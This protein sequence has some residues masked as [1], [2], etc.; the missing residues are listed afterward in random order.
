[1]SAELKTRLAYAMVKVNNGWQSRSLQE[2]ESLASRGASPASS[3]STINRPLGSSASPKLPP[4]PPAQINYHSNKMIPPPPRST[5]PKL[6][7]PASIQPNARRT[8]GQSR[9]TP[10]LMSSHSASATGPRPSPSPQTSYPSS[11]PSYSPHQHVREQDAIETLLFMSS[12]GNSA[13]MKHTFSPSASPAPQHDV[14]KAI[15]ARLDANR[16]PLPGDRPM[17]PNKKV[18]LGRSPLMAPPHS[19]MDLDSPQQHQQSRWTPRARA[20]G[21]SGHMRAALSLPSGLGASVGK[22]RPT[23]RDEDIERMLDRA[24]DDSSD[25]EEIQLPGR[26]NGMTRA[27]GV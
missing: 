23:L 27:L 21:A 22:A 9:Q 19:P 3:S 20:N 14:M 17:H 25:D 26:A 5:S 13:N 24:A 4:T 15:D 11:Q 16:R 10:K 12:P 2:V 1:M 8:S 7:P 18:G 6:A